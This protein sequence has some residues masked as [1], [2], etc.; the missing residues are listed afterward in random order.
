MTDSE[1]GDPDFVDDI[2]DLDTEDQSKQSKQD[3]GVDMS[4]PKG[5]YIP[6]Q[7]GGLDDGPQ[8]SQAVPSDVCSYGQ[9]NYW[10]D[11]YMEMAD[12][13]EWY[14]PYTI[15]R[16]VYL[17]YLRP[18]D[19]VL[20][21]GKWNRSVLLLLEAICIFCSIKHFWSAVNYYTQTIC[22]YISVCISLYIYLIYCC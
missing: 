20:I 8:R 14:H 12:Q 21:I 5:G 10:D 3:D 15:L 7:G 19:K 22:T 9:A 13:F 16:P 17:S 2:D 4:V 6:G 1:N 18:G 11:R